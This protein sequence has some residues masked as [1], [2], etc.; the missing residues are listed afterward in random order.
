MFYTSYESLE[1]PLHDADVINKLGWVRTNFLKPNVQKSPKSRQ[2][3]K[4][5]RVL[6]HFPG[7]LNALVQI[8]PRKSIVETNLR[9]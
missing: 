9:F 3:H 8:W 2:F 1:P 5:N 7:F 6:R 4:E